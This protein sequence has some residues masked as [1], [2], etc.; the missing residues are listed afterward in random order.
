MTSHASIACGDLSLI[1]SPAP[2]PSRSAAWWLGENA[3]FAT[4]E[5][6]WKPRPPPPALAAA[7]ETADGMPQELLAAAAV[8]ANPLLCM[9]LTHLQRVRRRDTAAW[10]GCFPLSA[11]DPG[12]A[13]QPLWL[14]PT[15]GDLVPVLGCSRR[16][17]IP[18]HPRPAALP[19]PAPPQA[20]VAGSWEVRLA[21]AQAISKI[22][23]R[24]GEPFRVQCYSILASARGSASAG[25]A[26]DAAAAAASDTRGAPGGA[27]G[28]G[29]GADA[30]GGAGAGGG[31][32]AG[33]DAAAGLAG[34]W[35]DPLGVA[36]C[37]G[38]ALEV[39]DH[40]YAG[41]HLGACQPTGW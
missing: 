10:A 25:A 16:L 27:A 35:R 12:P 41:A 29:V 19:S 20:M 6:I 9:I 11:A 22:G 3:N 38:P 28:F 18:S 2:P 39:M 33:A 7:L 40:M 1:S 13:G 30:A 31:A 24:S 36:A 14:K 17:P 23:I 8:G 32:S 5:F 26:S 4:N 15:Q 21:A 37:V 34:E